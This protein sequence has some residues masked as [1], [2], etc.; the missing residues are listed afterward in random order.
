MNPKP[1]PELFP[2]FRQASPSGVHPLRG[3]LLI[4]PSKNVTILWV[5]MKRFP[6]NDEEK[7]DEKQTKREEKREEGKS[8]GGQCLVLISKFAFYL[9]IGVSIRRR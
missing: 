3:P 4:L 7:G 6:R 1:R 5:F 2:F 9:Y 8:R